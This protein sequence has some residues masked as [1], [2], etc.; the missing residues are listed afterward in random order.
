MA[1]ENPF[2]EF[3]KKYPEGTSFTDQIFENITADETLGE[4][5][6]MQIAYMNLE[7][8]ISEVANFIAE[9]I[10]RDGYLRF[11]ID[12]IC[13]MTKKDVSIVKKALDAIQSLEPPGIGARNYQEC[14]ILQMKAKKMEQSLAFRV[15]SAYGQEFMSGRFSY[16]KKK[17]KLKEAELSSVISDIGKLDPFPARSLISSQKKVPVFP[18]F[19]IKSIEPNF[20]MEFGEDRVFRIFVNEGYAGLL[21]RA[22]SVGDRNYLNEKLRQSR[23]FLIYLE[24]RKSFLEK[25]VSY[26]AGYQKQFIIKKGALKPLSE[27]GLSEKFNCSCSMISRAVANKFVTFAGEVF[28]LKKLFSRPAGNLSQDFIMDEIEEIIR[29]ADEP[30][31]DRKISERLKGKGISIAPRTVNKYRRKKSILNS[32]IRRSLNSQVE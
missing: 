7:T 13:E 30:L 2:L 3:E 21:K 26:I 15:I 9:L 12:E 5:L 20:V 1:E 31:S 18:D 19:I 28:P 14:F 24:N 17:M 27:K 11:S 29:N 25:L 10:D 8:T 23:R 4:R 6:K 16:I 22:N 32:Y